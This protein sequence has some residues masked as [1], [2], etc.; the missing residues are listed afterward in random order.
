MDMPWICPSA[1]MPLRIPSRTLRPSPRRPAGA[2]MRRQ[3]RLHAPQALAARPRGNRAACAV[4]IASRAP[5]PRELSGTTVRQ[6]PRLIPSPPGKQEIE[7]SGGAGT[8]DATE[9][10]LSDGP[11]RVP[12]ASE[13]AARV[14]SVEL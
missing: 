8:P 10:S 2:R 1:D 5:R 13:A 4:G 12:R 3:E 7:A 6:I 11:E 9:V 14:C